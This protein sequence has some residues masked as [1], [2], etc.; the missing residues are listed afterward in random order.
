MPEQSLY[1]RIGGEAAITAAVDVFYEKVMADERTRPFFSGLDMN[2]Q[3]RKQRAFMTW[4]FGGPD[5][6][7]GRDLKAAH[8]KLVQER[9]LGDAHFDAVAQHLKE[10]L[11]ELAVPQALIDEVLAVVGGTRD[12]V[13]GRR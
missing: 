1:E 11:I 7:R 2:A 4:A 6:Y 9:G 13:L 3:I 12:Q 10:T 8:A 5:E